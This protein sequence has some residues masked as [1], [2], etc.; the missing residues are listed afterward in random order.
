[1]SGVN[2][3]YNDLNIA[4]VAASSHEP[5]VYTGGRDY[6]V[7]TWDSITG[8]Q[9]A[10]YSASRNIVTAMVLNEYS[11]S[12]LLYQGSEDLCIRVWDV[13]MSSRQPPATTIQGFV[14]FPTSLAINTENCILAAGCKG[15]EGAGG[16]IK[17]FDLRTSNQL[18]VELNNNTHRH[19]VTGVSFGSNQRTQNN[20]NEY[21]PN[22]TAISVSKDGIACAWKSEASNVQSLLK[23]KY[24]LTHEWKLA[25]CIAN[26]SSLTCLSSSYVASVENGNSDGKSAVQYRCFSTPAVEKLF[27]LKVFDTETRW[28]RF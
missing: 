21:D 23:T 15:I 20:H 16:S 1:V 3:I 22:L 13:R 6:A 11:D 5:R 2:F 27:I 26:Q 12:N 19:D 28:K 18:I 7:K 24:T 10:V 9:I 8:Q 17:L 14:Y 4:A 25:S